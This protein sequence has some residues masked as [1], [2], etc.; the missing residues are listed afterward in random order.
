MGVNWGNNSY[1]IQR[2][3]NEAWETEHH[4]HT[5]ESWFGLAAVP[6]ATHKADRIGEPPAGTYT[7]FTLTAGARVWSAWVQLLGSGDTPARAGGMV[8]YDAHRFE[9]I[10][11][12]RA[13]P[14][15]L[16]FAIGASGAAGLA[17]GDYSEV[18][19]AP[20]SGSN[21]SSPVP[22]MMKRV[23]VGQL[24]W[25]RGLVDNAGT[26]VVTFFLGIH[27]YTTIPQVA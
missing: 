22:V 7:P 16:Q 24:L 6:T 19:Y 3:F 4:F 25:V 21:D 5:Y 17:A 12:S 11:S 10:A 13:N 26:S 27:E 1:G 8:K 14:H 9:V 23:D 2:I 20:L 15:L 18:I